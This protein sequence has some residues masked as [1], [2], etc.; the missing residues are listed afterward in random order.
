VRIIIVARRIC[1]AGDGA[2]DVDR[3]ELLQGLAPWGVGIAITVGGWWGLR[4]ASEAVQNGVAL[5]FVG[6]V[7]AAFLF[8]Y[9]M[10]V[11]Y[12]LDSK[13]RSW[14]GI[15]GY[16]VLGLLL[17]IP[18]FVAAGELSDRFLGT[19]TDAFVNR[20]QVDTNGPVPAI[21]GGVVLLIG[22]GTLAI[23]VLDRDSA[24]TERFETLRATVIWLIGGAALLLW[25]PWLRQR[26]GVLVS[27]AW[28]NS[29]LQLDERSG[30]VVF[31]AI[32]LAVLLAWW[33]RR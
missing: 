3:E 27:D 7:Y 20:L 8:L 24:W 6:V 29:V 23:V 5:A 32:G 31:S 22:L 17:L 18:L 11:R 33:W 15:A 13:R 10:L 12:S 14:L 2:H 26:A 30:V 28:L 25:S 4:H 9:G 19:H 1:N 16:G 21:A